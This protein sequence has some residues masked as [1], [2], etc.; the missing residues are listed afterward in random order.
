[1]LS[2]RRLLPNLWRIPAAVLS[3]GLLAFLANIVG[4]WSLGGVARWMRWLHDHRMYFLLWRLLLYSAT[5]YGWLSMRRRVLEVEPGT[6]TAVRL[7]RVEVAG[8][9][10]LV[11][12]E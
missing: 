8:V 9:V 4:I 2:L 7:L 12:M 1:M 6:A 10:T 11:L 3:L 5:I